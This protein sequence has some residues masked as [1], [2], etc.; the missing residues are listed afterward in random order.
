MKNTCTVALNVDFIIEGDELFFELKEKYDSYLIPVGTNEILLEVKADMIL[1]CVKTT[2][3]KS[4][5]K[6]Y[7]ENQLLDS[8]QLTALVKLPTIKIE[9]SIYQIFKTFSSSIYYLEIENL[10][11]IPA[12][13]MFVVENFTLIHLHMEDACIKKPKDNESP[14]KL[15][16]NFLDEI[17]TQDT[18]VSDPETIDQ[19]KLKEPVKGTTK[20]KGS[21]I[22]NT[23]K[24]KK[25][26]KTLNS[27][28][29]FNIVISM[30]D[31]NK[32]FVYFA[33]FS[34]I[35]NCYIHKTIKVVEDKNN[36]QAFLTL[37][38]KQGSVCSFGKR[39]VSL[40]LKDCRKSKKFDM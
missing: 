31:A 22:G 26:P 10:N 16:Q 9:K 18:T 39:I 11:E 23:Y 29:P 34:A 7:Y 14:I 3:F 15:L 38:H 5:L 33:I 13:Y 35:V 27:K 24:K 37:D 12:N 4:V 17:Y 8:I 25:K 36:Y 19:Y 30:D 1:S 40:Q 6:A 2:T 32:E 20:Q 28:I 21:Y